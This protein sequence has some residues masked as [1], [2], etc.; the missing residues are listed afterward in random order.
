MNEQDKKEHEE[1]LARLPEDEKRAKRL[2]EIW[3]NKER[4]L[5]RDEIRFLM[6]HSDGR[7]TSAKGRGRHQ[8][9]IGTRKDVTWANHSHRNS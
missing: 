5:T 3:K 6:L 7:D 2:K 8:A 1:A 9:P 4:D